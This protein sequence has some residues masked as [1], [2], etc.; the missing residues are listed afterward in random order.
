MARE[1]GVDSLGVGKCRPSPWYA[2]LISA[3]C[4]PL[5]GFTSCGGAMVGR[6]PP[7]P[8]TLPTVVD[9]EALMSLP[10][11]PIAPAA[12]GGV[13]L[14]GEQTEQSIRVQFFQ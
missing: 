3:A 4:I 1:A 2:R 8:P 14:S 5:G 9:K 7:T 11:P 10:P 13:F 12:V 6:T